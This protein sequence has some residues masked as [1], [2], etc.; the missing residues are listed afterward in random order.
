MTYGEEWRQRA[1]NEYDDWS[2]DEKMRLFYTS[3][4]YHSLA[5]RRARN[6]DPTAKHRLSPLV[7]D[8]T[9]WQRRLQELGLEGQN[10]DQVQALAMALMNA[11]IRADFNNQATLQKLV[12]IVS[13]ANFMGAKWEYEKAAQHQGSETLEYLFRATG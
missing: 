2:P 11:N 1:E 8:L 3:S 13:G 9:T 6:P 12:G 10:A 4:T 5:A 7:S